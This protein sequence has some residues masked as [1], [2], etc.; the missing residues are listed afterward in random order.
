[1]NGDSDDYEY[2]VEEVSGQRHEI[3]TLP[4]TARVDVMII[5]ERIADHYPAVK[6]M[7]ERGVAVPAPT[8]TSICITDVCKAPAAP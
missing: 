2:F 4:G 6:L 3:N 5:F 7:E 8:G 1:M